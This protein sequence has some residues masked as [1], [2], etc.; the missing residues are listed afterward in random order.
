MSD[1][2][3]FMENLNLD[4]NSYMVMSKLQI[5]R[6]H[7]RPNY[8]DGRGLIISSGISK[9]TFRNLLWQKLFRD[10]DFYYI[11]NTTHANIFSEK[12]NLQQIVD[13][14]VQHIPDN[15]SNESSIISDKPSL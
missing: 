4:K 2:N 9:G 7:Y 14:I 5:S 11:P 1:G 6:R 12:E 13:L 8:F 3:N 10:K 15:G